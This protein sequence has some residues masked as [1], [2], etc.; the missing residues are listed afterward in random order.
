GAGRLEGTA[1][2]SPPGTGTSVHLPTRS[3]NDPTYTLTAVTVTDLAG[4]PLA[5]S[6]T[7]GGVTI[8]PSSASFPGTPPSCGEGFLCKNGSLGVGGSGACGTDADCAV[9]SPCTAAGAPQWRFLGLAG[10]TIGAL[11]VDPTN[12]Q[13]LYAAGRA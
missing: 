4:N 5:P 1:A 13:V 9:Y 8:D 6:R 12:P 2:E 11:A 7:V 3:Q 10:E